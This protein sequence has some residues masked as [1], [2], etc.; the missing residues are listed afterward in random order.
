MKITK[1]PI[2]LGLSADS[3]S[4]IVKAGAL[5]SGTCSTSIDFFGS[6]KELSGS[7]VKTHQ[8]RMK[9]TTRVGES[10]RGL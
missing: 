2:L 8:N 9:Q 4:L 7:T 5:F 3:K 6:C 10:G 1:S